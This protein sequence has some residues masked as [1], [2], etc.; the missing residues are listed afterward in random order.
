M[1]INNTTLKTVR[2]YWR[3][4]NLFALT[5]SGRTEIIMK[6]FTLAGEQVSRVVQ[7]CMRTSRIDQNA[8]DTLIKTDLEC[9]INFFDH[10]NV[11]GGGSCES[12]F[13]QFLRDNPSSREK[14]FIQTKCG[15]RNRIYDSSK[16]EI[17]TSLEGSLQRLGVDYVDFLLIHRPDILCDPEEVAEAFHTLR[18]CGKVRHFGVSNHNPMQIELLKKYLGDIPLSVNQLQFSL[19]NTT[20]IDADVNVNMENPAAVSHDGYLL[21][22]CRLNDIA[23]QP[24]SPFQYGLC[25][26]WYVDNPDFPELNEK[27]SEIAARYDVTPMGMVIAWMLRHPAKMQPIIGTTNPERVRQIA[28]AADVTITHDEWYNLYRAGGKQLP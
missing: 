25:E 28:K 22:Y 8:V 12:K 24:W 10:S 15:L 20:L 11:Y 17:L 18:D 26:G 1:V 21:N 16:R 19:T 27:L 4:N 23:I 3:I 13:G 9:G 5:L 14:L 2:R 6:Y 7:G